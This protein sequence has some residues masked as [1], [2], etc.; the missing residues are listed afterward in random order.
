[1]LVPSDHVIPQAE[2]LDAFTATNGEDTV[3]WLGH[4][5]F[6]LRLNGKVI[7][8]DP[9]LSKVA[10]PFGF[11]PER[12][13]A[14]G[15]ALD[16]LPP[17]DIILVSHNHYD[18]LDAKT[19][20]AISGKQYIKVV[21]PLALGEFFRQRG[22]LNVHE[23]DWYESVIFDSIKVQVL[24]AYHFSRRGPFDR[25]RTLWGGFSIRGSDFSIYHSGDTGYGPLFAEIGERAGLFDLALVAI[26]AY[27]P[28]SIMQAVHVTPEEAVQLVDDIGKNVAIGMHW[29]TVQLTDEN[30]F[31]PAERFRAAAHAADWKD[32]RGRIL[33]HGET[34]LVS[35]LRSK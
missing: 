9:Y 31:E 13:V 8:T 34:I 3:T 17:I 28:S 35:T 16:S 21:V 23:L 7:L 22:Y 29:G 5:A 6:L 32:G 27:E 4:A 26:G 12:Y 11:G 15:L 1:M 24:P 10:G 30:P 20:E 25:N 2:A 14:P 33:K 18:H 19:I